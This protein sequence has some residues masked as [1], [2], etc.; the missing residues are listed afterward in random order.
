MLTRD[1]TILT[2]TE[3]IVLATRLTNDDPDWV[4]LATDLGDNK[5]MVEVFDENGAYV[6][7]L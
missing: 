1:I 6:N 5:A 3:A 7:T 2:V 4:Y